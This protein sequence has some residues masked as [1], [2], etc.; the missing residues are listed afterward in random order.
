MLDV[1]QGDSILLRDGDRAILVDGGGSRGGDIGGRVLLPALLGEGVT[2]LEALVMTH[3]DADHCSGLVDV[4]AYLPVREVWMAP[5]WDPQGCAGRLLDLPGARTRLLSRGQRLT[6]GRWRLTA[7]HPAAADDGP[8]N[9]R[10]LV[11]LAEVNGRRAL[12]TGDVESGAERELAACCAQGLHADLLKVAHHGSRTSSTAPFLEAVAPRLALISVGLR[13]LYHHPAPEIVERLGER[14]RLLRTDRAGEI[15][16][17]FG[18][19]GKL[20]IETPGAPK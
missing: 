17:R 19:D 2:R 16:V 6:L 4:A 7:L 1:G 9:E 11:L 20:R 10:S 12:L 18:A 15:V 3:P 14:A 8:V 13:N 5:G